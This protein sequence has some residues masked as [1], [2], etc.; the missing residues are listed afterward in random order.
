[1]LLRRDPAVVH[2]FYVERYLFVLATA[3]VD[4]RAFELHT[5]S[6]HAMTIMEA[7]TPL[8]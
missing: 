5:R 2:N 4:H 8:L 6:R 1:M 7:K 3:P